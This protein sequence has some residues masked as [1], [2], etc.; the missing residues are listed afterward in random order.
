MNDEFTPLNKGEIL[1]ISHEPFGCQ[2]NISSNN[3]ASVS[4]K[5]EQFTQVMTQ[6]LA[7]GDNKGQ[8]LF[9]QGINCEV[10]RFSTNGWQKGK[11]RARV[12]LEFCPDQ[13]PIADGM[14][15]DI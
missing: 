8:N 12:I 9:G 10:L 7:V 15:S 1:S 2:L 3:F 4:L 11:L 6:R 5:T 13:T 14:V